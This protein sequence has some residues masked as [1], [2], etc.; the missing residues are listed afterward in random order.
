MSYTWANNLLYTLTGSE[1]PARPPGGNPN[2]E[3]GQNK[4][5]RK[6]R[7]DA[8]GSELNLQHFDAMWMA[9]QEKVAGWRT[10]TLRFPSGDASLAFT[11]DCG[12]GSRPD[13]RS[14]L[15]FDAKTGEVT[16]YEPYSSYN[17]G[18]KLRFWSRWMHTGEAAGLIGQII[19][20][21]ASAGAAVLVWTGIALAIRR[22]LGR[23]SS[24]TPKA[25]SET[26]TVAS[27]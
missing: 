10:I 2:G 7:S 5:G 1:A 8:S 13:L 25:A 6:N 21:L 3:R 14:Q 16:S 15:N 26:A 11:I 17:A 19:A 24:G 9:A 12:N 22:F 23:K 27:K 4:E 18:R 20:T